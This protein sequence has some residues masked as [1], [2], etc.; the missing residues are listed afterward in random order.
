MP[1]P[2][3]FNKDEAVET[4]MQEIWSHGYSAATVKSLSEKLGITR[5]SFYNAFDTREALFARVMKVY[6]A[7]SP[8]SVLADIKPGEKVVPKIVGVFREVARQRAADAENRGCMIIN[9]LNEVHSRDQEIWDQATA[10]VKG[11]RDRFHQL[12]AIARAQG[13]IAED[14]DIEALAGAL[15]T[16][17]AG[18]NTMA[19]AVHD[20]QAL[21]TPVRAMLLA[22]GLS[23][24]ADT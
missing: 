2:S 10:A 15:Q 14:A 21:W 3:K 12:L 11:G 5:S 6:A 4:V 9:T 17:L 8:D 19:R 20:E 7:H 24:G 23:D 22:L 18:M 1:R 16:L 13:E